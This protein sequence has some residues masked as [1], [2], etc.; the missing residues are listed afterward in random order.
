M[1][2][3]V[4]RSFLKMQRSENGAVAVLVGL[5]VFLLVLVA[6]V[7]VDMARAQILHTKIQSAL[8]ASGLAAAAALSNV[9]NGTSEQ[10]WATQQAQ[11]Y[12][13]ANFPSGYLGTSA[14]TVNAV[15][16]EGNSVISLSASSTQETTFMKMMGINSVN[17]A[18]SSSV[19]RSTEGQGLELVLVL[20]NTGSMNC[21][22][23]DSSAVCD[24]GPN[25]KIT[26]LKGAAAT[27]L[28]SL[29]GATNDTAPGL[30]VGIVPFS[31]AVN[32]GQNHKD[33]INANSATGQAALD[34]FD[35]GPGGSWGGCVR[36]QGCWGGWKA[37]DYDPIGCPFRPYWYP[38]EPS[39]SAADA[40][41]RIAQYGYYMNYNPRPP[42]NPP[43]VWRITGWRDDS[44]TPATYLSPLDNITQGPNKGCPQ[45]LTQMTASKANA[46]AAINT[47]IATG[48]TF[49]PEGIVWGGRMLSPNWRPYWGGEMA[50]NNLPLDYTTATS[51]KAV[52]L[53]SD[54]WNHF[55]PYNFSA[56][57][58]VWRAQTNIFNAYYSWWSPETTLDYITNE[59]C[60]SLKSNGVII[61]TIGFGRVGSS[62]SDPS[63]INATLLE[64]CATSTNHF[65]LAPTNADLQAAFRKIG[66]SLTNL[67]VSQ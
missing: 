22:V 53:M 11:R 47:M 17:V 1:K 6:S 21:N 59:I 42:G 20:D 48:D 44:V 52:I 5:A 30:F 15:L 40:S 9:P 16:S 13:N 8:D 67:R 66:V 28:D 56:Y 2:R 41:A 31:Q 33:W 27:L 64:Q 3:T 19:T 4:I 60:D 12:F 57:N 10:D 55:L 35:W 32:I 63:S 39:S 61:Y 25:T 18:A 7:A 49:I 24:G 36:T 46:K 45:A 43:A 23:S 26:A 37:T 51:R 54:G 29:Y 50:A 65:F 58:F 14:I 34:T 38:P 62:S